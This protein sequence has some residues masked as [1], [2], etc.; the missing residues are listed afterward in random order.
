MTLKKRQRAFTL[1]E[2]LIVVLIIAILA[3]IAIP[4]FMEFQVRA[5]VARAKNDMRTLAGALEAYHVENG[6]YPYISDHEE[7]EWTMPAGFPYNR[8]SPGGL[9]TP[10][11]YLVA[12]LPDPFALHVSKGGGLWM[13]DGPPVL[14]YERLGFGFDVNGDPY[15][16]NGSGFRAVHVP[17]DANGTIWGTFNAAGPETD[18]TTN[19]GDVPTEYVLFSIGPDHTHRIYN[20]DGTIQLKSRWSVLN[21]YDPTNGTVSQGNIVRFPGGQGGFLP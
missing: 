4:N 3:A 14:H 16:D 19:R 11:A 21:Y 9:T 15:N 8:T 6:D 7:G 20:Q 2:L 5:K 1:I 12:T 17:F 18:E 13:P 10:I